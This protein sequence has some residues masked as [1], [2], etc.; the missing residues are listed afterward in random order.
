MT[1]SIT[2]R[3]EKTGQFGVAVSTRVPA[4]GSLC[5]FAKAGTGAIATQSF[6]NP[7]IGVNGLKY[8]EQGLSAS[9]VLKKVLAEDPEPELR[10]VAIV[11]KKGNSVAFTGDKSDTWKGHLTGENYAVAGNMLVGEDTIK[12]MARAFEDNSDSSF[13]ERLLSALEAGQTAGGDKRGRQSAALYVVSTEAY[14]F[15]DLRVDEHEDPV[16]ELRRVFEVA[17]K[18]LSPFIN[19]LPTRDNPKGSFNFEESR[20]MGLLQD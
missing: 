19:M 4:V 5:P 12:E 7:Y 8:L 10:Q 17:Q 15:L 6:V 13:A 9:E 11:D 20:S 2:A 3:C 14:P 18:Q 1:F 16:K